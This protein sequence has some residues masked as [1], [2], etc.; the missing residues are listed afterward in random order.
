M[1]MKFGMGIKVTT[2]ETKPATNNI[3]NLL[4]LISE[5]KPKGD[6]SKKFPSSN[7]YYLLFFLKKK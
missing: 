2:A 1:Q 6:I 3:S 5:P 7:I 4:M